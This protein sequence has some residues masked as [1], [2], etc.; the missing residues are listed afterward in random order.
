MLRYGLGIVNVIKGAAAVLRGAVALKFGEAALIPELH[1]E[2]DDGA[3]LLL[4]KRGNGGRVNTAGH[5]YGDEAALGFRALRQGVE[6]GERRHVQSIVSSNVSICLRRDVRG[7]AC[8]A[9]TKT[10]PKW[11]ARIIGGPWPLCDRWGKVRGAGLRRRGLRSRR[12][13]C[14]WEWGG[15]RG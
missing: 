13:R 14:R 8:C 2:A 7:A 5:S 10:G 4:E 11:G 1:G 6:L 9:P 15:G 12:S 3:A